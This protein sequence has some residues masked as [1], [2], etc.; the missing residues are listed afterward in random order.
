LSSLLIILLERKKS[1]YA[2]AIRHEA[3]MH[4]KRQIWKYQAIIV[5]KRKYMAVYK[6]RK[7]VIAGCAILISFLML[8]GIIIPARVFAV[9]DN[10]VTVKVGYYE[11]EVFQEGA[12]QGAVKTGYAYE[13]YQK[14]AEYTGW[15]YE[16][17]YGDFSDLYQKL[18]DGDIDVLAGL[19][20]KKEREELLGYPELPMGNETYSLIKHIGD[21]SITVDVATLEGKRVGVLNSAM[22]DTLKEFLQEHNAQ[23][24]VV[25]FDN[26]DP[27][28]KAF[29]DNEVDVVAVEGDGTYGR[30]NAEL[31]YH[32]GASD[33]FLCVSKKRADLLA[34]LNIAQ[35]ELSVDEP[36]YISFLRSKY[37]PV[38]ISSRAFSEHE[39][40]WLAG[41]DSLRIGYLNNYLPY[42]GTDSDGEVNG[43][44][45]DL[46]PRMLKELG[47]DD[48]KVSYTGYDS[49]DKMVA[50]MEDGSVDMIFPVG[51]GLYY[52]EENGIFQ[53]NAVVSAATELVY[54]DEY[55]DDTVRNFAVNENN[56]MQYYFVN[57]YYP[58]AEITLYP[59]I[60]ECL[61]AVNEGK[62]GC[63]TLN[64]L[65]ANDILRNSRYS[66]LSL[67]QTGYNDDRSF[68][69]QIGNE[70]LLK[71]VNRG[72]N[73]LGSDYAQ[74]LA[75][76]YTDQLH[77]YSFGDVVRDNMGVVGSIML[78]VAAIIIM[79][80]V[81]DSKRSKQLLKQQERREQ[82]EKMITALASDYRCVYHVDLDKDDAVCYRSD[83]EDTDH[84]PEGIHFPYM[85]RFT[86]YADNFVAENYR[87][88]FLEFIDPGNVRK[89]LEKDPIIAYRYLAE[90]NGRE[91][92][93]MIRMAGVRHAENRED[94]IVHA[95]G[96]GLT[97][98]DTEM[99]ETMA[100]NQ[101]LGEALEA[102]EEANRAKT[103]FLSSVSH[104]IRT[105]M[106]A[107]IGL[108]SLALRD[109]SL[110]DETREYLEQIGGSARH[111]LGLINDILDMSRIESGRMVI[112]K[113]EFFF[114]DM[115]EQ[116][117]TMVM[118]QCEEKGLHYE[119]NVIGGVSD[120]Y[121]GDDMKLK[122]V[123][124]NILSNAIKFTDA[125]ENVML[126]V[127]R[128]A[129]YGDHTTLKFCISD[130]G[131]GMDEEFIP[132]IFDTFTQED[133]SR[134]SKYGSTGL[135]MAI[136]KNIVE[137]MNGTISV[138]SEKGV[139]TEFTVNITLNNSDHQ[140]LSSYSL[141][142]KDI[143]VLVVD[144]EEIAAEHAR[145]VLDEAGIKADTCYDGSTALHMLEVQHAKHEPYNLVLLDW[146]MPEMDGVEVA[147]EIRKKYD[148]ETT[149]IILTSFNWDEIMEEAI[150]SGVDSFLA[151]PLFASNVL[152]ELERIARK[153][154]M[155]LFKEKKRAELKG[156]K[157]LMAEDV[158][159]N[160]EIMK[161]IILLREAEIDH[162]ENGRI[163]L[164]M[165]E[166]SQ[167]GYYDAILM[168]VR[169]PEM[170]GLEAASAIR[171]LDRTDA[172]KIPII[173]L[174]ANAFDEDVQRSLQVGMNAHLSKPVDP[175]HLYQT[176]EELIWEY[177]QTRAS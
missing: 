75:F 88:G 71:L 175:E 169:M 72:I 81:R 142:P 64:G 36:N 67:R 138:K 155:S 112:R 109:E 101:A 140:G 4:D 167:V 92:Y 68:G 151:K 20:W 111:L 43:L 176:L 103:A 50:G 157:I 125:P 53:S 114:R 22:A 153:N 170:D 162:A 174:T 156:R 127:E 113:E 79:F 6:K 17:V 165:F 73:I 63:T 100:K 158:F 24:E 83:P 150:H 84:T 166:N 160:A 146:K 66:G 9:D 51:G 49:S 29:D 136:T 37:Y 31:L 116:I 145:I 135:G 131:I 8:A 87:A 164:E 76:Q 152:D 1:V 148:K 117:N 39:R 163:V 27:L 11:N 52:A 58:D 122:Q 34:D 16:Y 149:V 70:G 44:L 25:L 65:R 161:Q 120:Y 99:R 69:V 124:I 89:A 154:N 119:C 40:E 126:T 91:Y 57:T 128:T 107:I 19:A 46:I 110:P 97:V 7:A 12:E 132:K 173:A 45:K 86:W 42:S 41:H 98:I 5:K 21:G 121:I 144:D 172:K 94:H 78:A 77:S 130:T 60:D 106:N 139:G 104:E 93:E 15:H 159:V 123:L 90:R 96:L 95:V 143:R 134:N 108:D 82:Q 102:A 141:N 18:L 47:L 54:K 3:I 14:L 35:T 74:N 105:P 32:F 55:N 129:V 56:R 62:A 48:L 85:E 147:R 59:S 23:A 115:L 38:S 13:Y 137:L 10:S 133:S 2:E 33:Y 118:S 61:R 168:D 26:Y 80:L 171:A 30:T 177:S 28:F